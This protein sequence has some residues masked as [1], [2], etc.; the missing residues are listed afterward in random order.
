[1]AGEKRYK[2]K[3]EKQCMKGSCLNHTNI[4]R[5]VRVKKWETGATE[6][7]VKRVRNGMERRGLQQGKEEFGR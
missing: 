1:M 6:L 2:C 5:G 7:R 3:N 4:G